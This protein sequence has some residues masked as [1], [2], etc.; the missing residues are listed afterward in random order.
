MSDVKNDDNTRRRYP[1]A[2]P[3][4]YDDRELFR[5]RDKE[6][7]ELLH[8]VLA[9]RLV[10]VIGRSGLGKSSLIRAGILE[11]LRVRDY[12]PLVVRVTGGDNPTDSFFSSLDTV[13]NE[14]KSRFGIECLSGPSERETDSFWTLFKRLELWRE[15]TLLSP[16]L[17]L[18]QF[19]ELFT[20]YTEKERE[21]FVRELSALVRGV[22][23]PDVPSDLDDRVPPVKVVLVMREDFYANLEELREG[24]PGIYRSPLRLNPLSQE[25]AREAIV[26]PAAIEGG[27]FDTAT[28]R[29]TDD[30]LDAVI[31]FLC[32]RQLGDGE[33]E[34]GTEVEPFQLQLVC[35][36]IEDVVLE[37]Q[38]NEVASDV[39]GGETQLQK[40]LGDFYTRAL[41]QVATQFKSLKGLR[42]KMETLCE[43]NFITARGRRLLREESEIVERDGVPAQVLSALVERRLLRREPRIGDRYYEL[44]HD[45]LIAPIQKSREINERKARRTRV[46]AAIAAGVL[47]LGGVGFN[48]YSRA[49]YQALE[50]QK[51]AQSIRL[52]AQE[53][54]ARLLAKSND[55]LRKAEEAQRRA[56]EAQKVVASEKGRDGGDS[57][58]TAEATSLESPIDRSE[59]SETET[60]EAQTR[61]EAQLESLADAKNDAGVAEAQAQALTERAEQLRKEAEQAVSSAE[62]Q[63]KEVIDQKR[64]ALRDEI[65]QLRGL[66]AD[67]Q[68]SDARLVSDYE[69]FLKSKGDGLLEQDRSALRSELDR[70]KASRDSYQEITN[71][72]AQAN[73]GTT[74]SLCEQDAL[75]AGFVAAR[76]VGP[77]VTAK[78][79]FDSE[80]AAFRGAKIE[81][82]LPGKSQSRERF[83]AA[84]IV[85]AKASFD[86]DATKSVTFVWLKDGDQKLPGSNDKRYSDIRTSVYHDKKVYQPGPHAVE[87]VSRIGK[88]NVV[89][90]R[91]PFDVK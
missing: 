48:L 65:A 37:R 26:E 21:S 19:E 29:W 68:R 44:T 16:V 66:R 90:C 9:E 60:A 64:I 7:Y 82:T 24:I 87:V 31:S 56:T 12:L 45:T 83:S 85:R 39:V 58:T 47:I 18:D 42:K 3:F 6:T 79:N 30:A 41:D 77:E 14:A 5:G 8:M 63:A 75:W 49:Q 51:A 22:R 52:N 25:Q 27:D 13:L 71:A 23:P 61:A 50:S 91:R 10:V 69:A 88:Q 55:L 38:L 84:Q 40:V 86:S 46:S 36:H 32:R 2:R 4:E 33:T 62:T 34:Q 17:I 72:L 67:D 73:Q 43:R 28:F 1:G 57:K 59:V 70:L 20:L 54:K 35:Q 74:L 53:E 11:P 15:D 76:S 81:L 80:Y 78:A 89:V